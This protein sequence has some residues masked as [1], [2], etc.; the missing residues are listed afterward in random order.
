MPPAD[1]LEE[2]RE[3][4]DFEHTPE[5]SGN[6]PARERKSAPTFVIQKHAAS[7]LHYDFR[8]EVDGVLKSWAVRKGPSTDPAQ[9]RLAMPVEDHPM[10]YAGFEGVIPSGYGAG[11]VIVWDRGTY[12]NLREGEG[13]SMQQ[14]LGEGKAAVWLDGEKLRGGFSLVAMRGRDGWLLI[15]QNDDEA[16]PARDVTADAPASVLSGRTIEDLGGPPE[17]APAPRRKAPPRA[18]AARPRKPKPRVD[19]G[20]T[21]EVRLDGH[22]VDVT[23]PDRV[24][25]PD[26]GITKGELADYYRKIADRMLPYVQGR[27]LVLNRYP[28]GIEEPG[29]VQQ[30]A[31]TS[32]PEW[33]RRATVEKERG[34]VTHAVADSAAA[35]VYLANQSVVTL[36]VW[37]S[38]V[39]DLHHPDR[40]VFDLDP[41]GE[42][43]EPVR[44]AAR[45]VRALLDELGLPAFLMTTGSSGLHVV[46]PLDRRAD[47]DTVRAFARDAAD[48]LAARHPDV[49][50]AEQRK[51][52]REGRV[53]LDILRNTYAHTAVA[54]YA[55]RALPGAPVA[56]PLDWDELARPDLDARRYTVRNVFRRLARKAD[57]WSGMNEQA[58][59]LEEARG[60]LDR[61]R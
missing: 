27:P 44:R 12:R 21:K 10:G 7:T 52:K 42:D 9:K 43:F 37:Q 54:P 8:L 60:R 4:R 29:F 51:A 40:M 41:P 28:E 48:V 23:H 55:V 17:K 58:T 59:G 2:Y 11:T 34:T 5:P 18:E 31:S 30:H 53:F 16:D 14:A 38:R 39:D 46:T 45:A 26:S 57:P 20:E 6:T 33:L 3:K 35:L 32:A 19:E 56:T 15:K 22:T 24:L 25:F 36:H 47:F 50:T 13:V 49:L 61:L 1:P